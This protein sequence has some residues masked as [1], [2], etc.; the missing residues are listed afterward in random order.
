MNKAANR[1]KAIEN[2]GSRGWWS[3]GDGRLE[4]R[5]REGKG[6]ACR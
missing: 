1:R 2:G 3:L 4:G 5:G 6:R